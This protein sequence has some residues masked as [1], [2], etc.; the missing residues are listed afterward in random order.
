MVG[1]DALDDLVE[2]DAGPVADGAADLGE[3]RH[4]P[5]HVLEAVAVRLG[6]RDALDRGGAAGVPDDALG[7]LVDAHLLLVADVEDLAVG[8]G[9]VRQLDD[10]ADHVAHVAEA[11]GLVPVAEDGDGLA[12]EGLADEG[13][14]D[15]AVAAG[16]ARADGVE[17]A[18]DDD[19]QAPLAGVRQGEELVDGLGAGVAPPALV[20]GADDE[21]VVLPAGLHLA[22]AVD[23]GRRG[24]EDVLLLLRRVLQ[25]HLGRLQ[26][27]LDGAHRRL[28]HQA[29]AD[30]GGEVV[31]DVGPVDE[32]GEDRRVLHLVDDDVQALVG[33]Q[34]VEVLDAARR[35]VVDDV[36]LVAALEQRLREV[37]TD[38]AGAAGDQCLHGVSVCRGCF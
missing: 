34:V 30:G 32:L 6:V 13:G 7:E 2:R 38:E 5:A 1:H 28:D 26:V 21:V 18:G 27:G 17:E 20:G 33:P 24:E 15:H 16:L 19:G 22:L 8:G 37:G 31:D 36:D 3:V 29:H 14:D 10:G 11:A 12:G 4:A 35:E 9:R 25:D 23:L